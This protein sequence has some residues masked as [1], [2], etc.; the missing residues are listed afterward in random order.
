[1]SNSFNKG[2]FNLK[3]STIIDHEWNKAAV[4]A[5]IVLGVIAVDESRAGKALRALKQADRVRLD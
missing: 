5:T 4:A 3:T 2:C 1:M